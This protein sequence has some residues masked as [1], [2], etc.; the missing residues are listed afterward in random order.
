MVM[1]LWSRCFGP[2]C[3]HLQPIDGTSMHVPASICLHKCDEAATPHQSVTDCHWQDSC[4]SQLFQKSFTHS[5]TV[6]ACSNSDMIMGWVDPCLDWVVF[7]KLDRRTCL[8]YQTGQND[9]TNVVKKTKGTEKTGKECSNTCFLY[10]VHDR[11]KLIL[12]PSLI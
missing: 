2:S 8:F 1:S 12:K 3:I 6:P 10:S 4:K 9:R 11:G 5:H 7:C